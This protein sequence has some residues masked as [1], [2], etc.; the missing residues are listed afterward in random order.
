MATTPADLVTLD[1]VNDSL[2]SPLSNVSPFWLDVAT[3]SLLAYLYFN[4]GSSVWVSVGFL[5]AALL[6]VWCALR[7]NAIYHYIVD[8]PK[9]RLSSASQGF[10]E[11]HGTCDLF[12][13]RQTQG[14]MTGPP[15]VWHRYTIWRLDGIPFQLGASTLPFALTDDTGSC[16]VNPRGAK[17]ISSSRRT[18]IADGKRF[19]SKYICPGAEVYIL[20][21]L[22]TRGGSSLEYKKGIEVGKLLSQW[23]KDRR[24]LYGEFDTDG[25]GDLDS[26]EWEV[27]RAR[28]EKISY[29]LHQE[30]TLDAV[31]H[32]IGK[33]S[34]GMPFI[35]ADRDPTP[36]GNAFRILGVVNMAMAAVCFAWFCYSLF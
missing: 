11:L 33:P 22:R 31:S 19:S 27:A 15:C 26:Q 36:L 3:L 12:G 5:I 9:S 21:E 30:R 6:S 20:G 23:K 2:G 24:W 7:A 10:V 32:V 17:M 8:T 14:F 34:N 18:W 35:I 1:Q 25:D 4:G 28:A 16:V 13:N 29:R